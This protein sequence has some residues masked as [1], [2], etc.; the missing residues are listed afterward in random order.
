MTTSLWARVQAWALFD[1]GSTRALGLV[2]IAFSW[3]VLS[4][5]G[6]EFLLWKVLPGGH[7]PAWSSSQTVGLAVVGTLLL[8]S[9]PL[10]VVGWCTRQASVVFAAS[11]LLAFFWLGETLGIERFR[12]HH[13][14]LMMMVATGLALS[15]AGVSFSVDRWLAVRRAVAGGALVPLEQAP[16]MGQRLVCAVVTSL[17]LGGA[18]D[19]ARVAFLNGHEL[20]RIF[21]WYFADA[22]RL[23]WPWLWQVLAVGSV[24]FEAVLAVGL[25]SRRWQWPLWCAAAAF[26]A[27]LALTMSVGPFGAMTCVVSLL[28]LPPARID[29][30]LDMVLRRR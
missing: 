28:F 11:L 22:T 14:Q 26:H 20:E 16:L 21:C 25:W 29:A 2:R 19:K 12:H 8:S 1:E 15:P 24:V 27:V 4:T 30:V 18:V 10:V 17:Y 6:D 3:M 13:R 5:L 9:G 7:G 23:G